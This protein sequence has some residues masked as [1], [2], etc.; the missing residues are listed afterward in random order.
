MSW[1]NEDWE[2]DDPAD[3]EDWETEDSEAFNDWKMKAPLKFLFRFLIFRDLHT[4]C[5]SPVLMEKVKLNFI[6]SVSLVKITK[7][8]K[9]VPKSGQT[10]ETARHYKPKFLLSHPPRRHKPPTTLPK[11]WKYALRGS[12]SGKW[13]R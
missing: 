10:G 4:S 12:K 2:N 8:N 5:L 13:N 3:I 6:L 1:E 7:K 9:N 11:K